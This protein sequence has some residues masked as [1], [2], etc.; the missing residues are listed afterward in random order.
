MK[1]I[2]KNELYTHL[3]N[4][5]KSKGIELQQG[6]Y[7]SGIQ[8]SCGLLTDLINLS[9]QGLERARGQVE[10]KLDQMRQVIHQKTAPRRPS[11]AGAAKT[12]ARARSRKPKT[13]A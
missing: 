11:Q 2:E 10:K 9:Q 13:Q 4:Y 3:G 7:A 5:L 12:K 6:S 1:R 8:R